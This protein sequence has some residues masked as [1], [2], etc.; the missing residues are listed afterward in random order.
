MEN[1]RK[2]QQEKKSHKQWICLLIWPIFH[3]LRKSVSSWDAL[4]KMKRGG[5]SLSRCGGGKDDAWAASTY[6]AQCLCVVWLSTEVA[7]FH[8]EIRYIHCDLWW[9]WVEFMSLAH[10]HIFCCFN[11]ISLLLLLPEMSLLLFVRAGCFFEVTTLSSFLI[12]SNIIPIFMTSLD[13]IF[14]FSWV[15]WIFRALNL[16]KSHKSSGFG[17]RF[18]ELERHFWN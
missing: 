6:I 2:Q 17:R 15:S 13:V 5:S 14:E 3:W 9:Q 11:F 18:F 10:F 4:S 1:F 16:I 12:V 8:S 7:F